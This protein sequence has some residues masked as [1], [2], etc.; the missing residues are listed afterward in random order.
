MLTDGGAVSMVQLKLLGLDVSP[1]L[2]SVAV[3][4]KLYWP[5][6]RLE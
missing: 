6:A 5:S 4:L 3:A 2:V 1:S